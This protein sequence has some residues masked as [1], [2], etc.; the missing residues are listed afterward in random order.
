ME[1]KKRNVFW[2]TVAVFAV[3]QIAC[4][5]SASAIG[6]DN[7]DTSDMSLGSA[8]VLVVSGIIGSAIYILLRRR[9]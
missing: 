8:L 4:I 1:N 7:P 9:R 6:T 2:A 5:A 3:S